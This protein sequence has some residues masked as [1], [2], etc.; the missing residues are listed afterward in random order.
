MGIDAGGAGVMTKKPRSPFTRLGWA[1]STDGSNRPVLGHE[2]H[3][4]S[5]SDRLT[6]TAAIFGAGSTDAPDRPFDYQ[7]YLSS[8]ARHR[9]SP[10]ATLKKY[11]RL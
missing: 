2:G 7:T 3:A 5:D 4:L 11:V 6:G 9:L 10:E 1:P 8:G